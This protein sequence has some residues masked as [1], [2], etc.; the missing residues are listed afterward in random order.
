[1]EFRLKMLASIWTNGIDKTASTLRP[2]GL[3][4]SIRWW[5]EAFVRGL[6]GYACDPTAPRR[7]T[8][9]TR[10][11]GDTGNL[12]AVLN[13][14]CPACELFGCT[15]W[16]SKIQIEGKVLDANILHLNVCELKEL[17][18]D[19]KSLIPAAIRLI[20]EYGTLGAHT[21]LKPSE[22]PQKNLPG[23]RKRSHLDYGIVGLAPDFALP[24]IVRPSLPQRSILQGNERDWPDL[25]FFWFLP[26]RCLYR[27][28]INGMVGRNM[29]GVYDSPTPEQ[30]YVGGYIQEN[31]RKL[32]P[33]KKNEIQ[34]FLDSRVLTRV[35]RSQSESKKIFS[36]HGR[37]ADRRGNEIGAFAPRCFGYGRNEGERDRIIQQVK[38]VIERREPGIVVTIKTGQE[39]L[40]EFGLVS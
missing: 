7:C 3:R 34:Q 5:Y 39:V 22:E 1:M 27:D 37:S 19:E 4:G 16:S 25:R 21:T 17:T 13:E 14:L 12:R 28:E 24:D 40:R 29:R 23:Y 8:F 36:F 2:S 26:G 20:V 35:L 18:H 38:A 32:S 10:R 31:I 6:G 9:D 30:V 11:F 33:V 15:G